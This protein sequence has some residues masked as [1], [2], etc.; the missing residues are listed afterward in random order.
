MGRAGI[1]MWL[2]ANSGGWKGNAVRGAHMR[3]DR[4]PKV[5]FL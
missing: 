4:A 1:R 2:L 5:V 3:E